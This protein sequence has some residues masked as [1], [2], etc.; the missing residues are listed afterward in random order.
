MQ[1]YYNEEGKLKFKHIPSQEVIP[2]WHDSEHK[3]LDAV[4][5][6]YDIE[7][8][9]TKAPEKKIYEFIEYYTKEGVWKYKRLKAGGQIY[10]LTDTEGEG[11]FKVVDFYFNHF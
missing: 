11:H 8:Y 5:R 4:I 10:P 6:I 1:A 9:S 2:F 7:E 3:E